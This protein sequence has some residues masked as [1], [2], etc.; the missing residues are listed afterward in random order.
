MR[1]SELLEALK[2]AR[3]KTEVDQ[4]N[5]P[6]QKSAP[7][8]KETDAPSSKHSENNERV[9]AQKTEKNNAKKQNTIIASLN[10]SS[11]NRFDE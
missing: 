9:P 11:G 6:E 10:L 1:S 4:K 7:K 5:N 2:K 3:M 8:K